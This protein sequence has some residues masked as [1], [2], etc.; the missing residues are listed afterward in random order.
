MFTDE[1]T[2]KRHAQNQAVNYAHLLRV[3]M[4]ENEA[5]KKAEKAEKESYEAQFYQ[6]QAQRVER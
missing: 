5:R 6:K 2:T 1:S 4:A 3:Q